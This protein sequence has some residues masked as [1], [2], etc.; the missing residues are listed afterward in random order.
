MGNFK[1][2]GMLARG[3]ATLPPPNP[4]DPI[5]RKVSRDA[6]VKLAQ[7]LSIPEWI[8]MGIANIETRNEGLTGK[9]NPVLRNEDYW[10]TRLSKDNPDA[11]KYDGSKNRRDY[12][13]RYMQ[14]LAMRSVDRRAAILCHSWGAFQI[15]GFN[16]KLC[17]HESP[18]AFEVGMSTLPGQM[19]LFRTFVLSNPPLASAMRQGDLHSMAY[20]YNGKNH[21]K[22][23]YVEKLIAERDR[24]DSLEGTAWV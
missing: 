13:E 15:M 24:F 18:E 12:D 6:S 4:A 21:A 11:R 22:N 5:I 20:H 9:N 17:G 19:R 3:A 2:F 10:W 16:M 7:S 1:F 8:P 14:Y 23:H